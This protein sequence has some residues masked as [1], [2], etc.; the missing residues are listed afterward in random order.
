MPTNSTKSQYA[1]LLDAITRHVSDECLIWPFRTDRD[2]YGMCWSNN[3]HRRVHRIA[4][5][6]THG[7]WPLPQGHH[8]CD[9]PACFNPR[10][11]VEGTPRE[12]MNDAITKDRY[13]RGERVNTAKLTSDLVHH[14]RSV[15]RFGSGGQLARQFGIT[16]Q[17]VHRIVMRKTWTHIP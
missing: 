2:G 7:H 16:I 3:A 8:T 5:H 9:V 15:Y 17:E 4:F 1:W 12:N 11:I 6:L 13:T 14:I 10:H